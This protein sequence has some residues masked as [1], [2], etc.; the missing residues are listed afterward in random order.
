MKELLQ[1]WR[2]LGFLGAFS[3]A[4]FNTLTK[5]LYQNGASVASTI[6]Y[7]SLV[8]AA[9]YARGFSVP[10]RLLPYLFLL[11]LIGALANFFTMHAF[12]HA[13]NPGYVV[14]LIGLSSIITAVASMLFLKTPLTLQKIAGMVIILIGVYLI[15]A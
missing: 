14:P 13:P 9:I 6:L 7:P 4:A 15:V 11:G 10:S 1:D 2:L 5:Y 3:W 8:Y 12:K